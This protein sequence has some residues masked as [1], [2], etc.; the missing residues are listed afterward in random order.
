M[1]IRQL[2]YFQ[3][4]GNLGSISAAS[5][6]LNVT[7]PAIGM[8]IRAL[9]DETG[10]K[11]FTRHA[12][13]LRLTQ[14]GKLLMEHAAAILSGVDRAQYDL[15]RLNEN[16]QGKV[17]I[18]VTPSIC[19]VLVPRLLEQYHEIYPDVTLLF[20][21]GFKDDLHKKWQQGE[22]DFA[23]IEEEIDAD[24][25]ESIPLYQDTFCLIGTKELMGD[26][27]ESVPVNLLA[28]L[29][30]VL[31]GREDRKRACIKEAMTAL[32]CT[33]ENTIEIQSTDIRREYVTQG[34]RFCIAPK[35]LYDDE[36]AA[37]KCVAHKIDLATLDRT[38]SLAGPR[39]ENMTGTEQMVRQLII[40]IVDHAI[41]NNRF[42][43]RMPKD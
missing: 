27:P 8:Q 19:R 39:V 9:E 15:D 29:P 40:Q 38:I 16:T 33:F 6:E 21:I 30:I 37:G 32:N 4:V 42:G 13:G 7:A 22:T 35:A 24:A 34:Q 5:N 43:W 23:F 14:A 25:G 10:V 41:Q 1:E 2:K 11:L 36:I 26:I 3:T 17:H 18:G 31:D 12:R 20:S 28:P